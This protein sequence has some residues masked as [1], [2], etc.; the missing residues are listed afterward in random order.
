M[1]CSP[2]S[3]R[4]HVGTLA[5]QVNWL[6][7]L[8]VLC[9]LT[10]DLKRVNVVS[11][12]L[13]VGENRR[14]T[15]SCYRTDGSEETV[16]RSDDFITW[17][18]TESHGLANAASVHL[19]HLQCLTMSVLTIGR[20]APATTLPGETSLWV[21]ALLFP[22][23]TSSSVQVRQSQISSTKARPAPRRRLILLHGRLGLRPAM[24]IRKPQIPVATTQWPIC[25]CLVPTCI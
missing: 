2:R 9:D 7:S 17:S 14:C 24:L 4:Q 19:R 5:V 16:R 11:I 8:C 15:Q 21:R 23:S 10:L 18:Y 12:S 6:D 25:S 20:A 3:E 1:P 13:Y 22:I